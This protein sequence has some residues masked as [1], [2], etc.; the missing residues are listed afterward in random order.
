MFLSVYKNNTYKSRHFPYQ[1][2]RKNQFPLAADLRHS[3]LAK[4]AWD[5][6]RWIHPGESLALQALLSAYAVISS[7]PELRD[8]SPALAGLVFAILRRRLLALQ[9]Q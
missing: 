7:S 2:H 9:W 5:S 3:V 1:C 8:F 6:P 4:A